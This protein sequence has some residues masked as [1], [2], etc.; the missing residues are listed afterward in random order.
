MES[1]NESS[2][3]YILINDECKEVYKRFESIIDNDKYE[4]SKPFGDDK[5]SNNP[6]KKCILSG[7]NCE[8]TKQRICSF[9][10]VKK[11]LRRNIWNS[12]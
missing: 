6:L 5:L 11:N 1:E 12:C 9:N 3:T 8:K 2:K 10:S 4:N 7:D